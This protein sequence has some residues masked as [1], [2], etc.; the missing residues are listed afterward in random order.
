VY[1]EQAMALHQKMARQEAHRAARY[2][3]LNSI[4]LSDESIAPQVTKDEPPEWV[5]T[6]KSRAY[7]CPEALEDTHERYVVCVCVCVCV[8]ERVVV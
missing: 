4:L 3:Y 5:F 7:G 8:C 6:R 2:D 1:G